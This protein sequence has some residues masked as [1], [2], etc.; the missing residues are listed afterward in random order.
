LSL[1]NQNEYVAY[2]GSDEAGKGEWLGALV[3]VAVALSKQQRAYLVT[4]GVM[5]SKKLRLNVISEL[6]KVIQRSCLSYHAITISPH[7]FNNL[8]QQFRKE[9]RSLNDILAWA[10]AQA[11]GNVFE[12]LTKKGI[13]GKIKLSIDMFDKIK[14]EDRLKR[15]LDLRKFDLYHHP[16][17]ETETS[18][19]AASIIARSV[20]ELWIDERSIELNLDLRKLSVEQ[21]RSNP[22]ADYFAKLDFLKPK[23]KSRKGLV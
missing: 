15:V 23:L 6:A 22:S 2:I 11:I 10:H 12:E 5:D 1:E 8:I 17:A 14:T 16:K 7:S 18:V 20:R 4:Q 19:A 3:V 13:S 21:A 9:S